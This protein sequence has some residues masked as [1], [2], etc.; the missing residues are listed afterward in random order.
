MTVFVYMLIFVSA[1][2]QSKRKHVY[3]TTNQ[4]QKGRNASFYRCVTSNKLPG[5][6]W[7]AAPRLKVSISLIISLKS[8]GNFQGNYWDIFQTLQ[9]CKIKPRS[10]NSACFLSSA[11]CSTSV[12]IKTFSCALIKLVFLL[13]IWSFKHHQCSS[14][15]PLLC[16]YSD[17]RVLMYLKF[18]LINKW[19][20]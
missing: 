19:L 20:F 11:V 4:R 17:E 10:L 5:N 8:P 9:T 12:Q 18:V 7:P 13:Y 2:I 16:K 6:N 14:P 15:S 1:N 3:T